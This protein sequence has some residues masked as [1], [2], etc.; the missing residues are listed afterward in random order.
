[1][2]LRGILNYFT[3]KNKSIWDRGWMCEVCGKWKQGN[4]IRNY[5]PKQINNY[6]KII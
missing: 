1:M 2:G 5:L 3:T 6:I 4:T